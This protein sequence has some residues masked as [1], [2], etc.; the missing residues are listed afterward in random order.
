[1]KTSPPIVVECEPV[2]WTAP[3]R[4]KGNRMYSPENYRNYKK[5]MALLV[6][7]LWIGQ[8]SYPTLTGDIQLDIEIRWP[9]G[10]RTNHQKAIED[11]LELAGV[12]KND[13][14]I[15]SGWT[16]ILRTKERAGFTVIVT[17]FDDEDL[18]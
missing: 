5:A 17:A 3:K 14:Q 9:K 6:K 2:P 8:W 4:G 12:Y 18:P 11:I 10:D 15:V 7:S 13:V 1:M 16:E